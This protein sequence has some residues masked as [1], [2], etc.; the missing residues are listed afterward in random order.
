MAYKAINNLQTVDLDS[1]DT[2]SSTK[3]Y[4][5]G[6]V[7]PV[8]DTSKGG[9]SQFMYVKAHAAFATIGTPFEIQSGSGGNAEAITSAPATIVSGAV[10]GFNTTAVTSGYYFWAQTAGIL[11][12]AA[13]AGIAAGDHVEVINAGTTVIVDGTTGSTTQTT[14]S[15]GIAKTAT[16]TGAIDLVVLPSRTIEIAAT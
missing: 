10:L 6:T 12:A 8:N 3:E 16:A 1:L 4:P 9:E 13:A 15:I 7:L 5:L 2:P 14:R 11:V